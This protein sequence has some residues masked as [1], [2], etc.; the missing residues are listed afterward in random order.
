MVTARYSNDA[1]AGLSQFLRIFPRPVAPALRLGVP[2]SQ[3]VDPLNEPRHSHHHAEDRH[4]HRGA[5]PSKSMGPPIT[6]AP[7]RTT[8][9]PYNI[10]IY[11]GFLPT[12]LFTPE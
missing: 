6:N 12:L 11:K 3:C 5:R 10:L 1:T 8:A 9:L 4:E 2:L 7:R